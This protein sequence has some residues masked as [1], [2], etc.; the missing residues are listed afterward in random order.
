MRF[1]L[2]GLLKKK[3]EPVPSFD[4][5]PSPYP[6]TASTA[7]APMDAAAAVLPSGKDDEASLE[8]EEFTK[9]SSLGAHLNN[10][11]S[12]LLHLSKDFDQIAK[13][14]TAVNP[15]FLERM[16]NLALQADAKLQLIFQ[17]SESI[18]N[19]AILLKR[20]LM[21]KHELH[22]D[23]ELLRIQDEAFMDMGEIR[24]HFHRV[25]EIV[26]L[27]Q[28]SLVELGQQEVQ[29][30][31]HLALH[32]EHTD[33]AKEIY[34]QIKQGLTI[35][36]SALD[37]ISLL[38]Q[39]E[40]ELSE[41]TLNDIVHRDIVLEKEDVQRLANV[42][43]H[44][45]TIFA[46]VM[47]QYGIQDVDKDVLLPHIEC[48]EHKILPSLQKCMK[49]EDAM[50]KAASDLDA[51]MIEQGVSAKNLVTS[52]SEIRLFSANLRSIY[53][54]L[55]TAQLRKLKD[56]NA[57]I[58]ALS[59]RPSDQNKPLEALAAESRKNML[60]SLLTDG[61]QLL[62]DIQ[63]KLAY[64]EKNT[65]ALYEFMLKTPTGEGA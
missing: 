54:E 65:I 41:V 36:T 9:T 11:Y 50:F 8:H 22:T 1:P 21:H 5:A 6:V 32:V 4:D 43:T 58:N 45:Q 46:V 47:K 42:F 33:E 29:Q 19:L 49:Y 57:R 61:E 13:T 52:Q 40:N 23:K 26:S 64:L 55:N 34:A 17:E 16:M 27:I 24:A 60:R 10:L 20:K 18:R 44:L 30:S 51:R 35:V 15:E 53:A 7:D 39:L 2:S 12:I 25:Q 48:L 62:Y 14:T 56:I 38:A 59:L 63:G 3:A 37:H 31:S 28:V